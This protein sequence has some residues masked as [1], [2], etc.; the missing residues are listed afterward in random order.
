MKLTLTKMNIANI[1]LNKL[2]LNPLALDFANGILIIAIAYLINKILQFIIRKLC[3][4]NQKEENLINHSMIEATSKPIHFFIWM[5]CATSLAQLIENDIQK[6]LSDEIYFLRILLLS[7]CIIWFCFRFIN[8]YQKRF[9]ITAKMKNEK[10]D[11]LTLS[12]LEKVVKIVVFVIGSL[13]VLQHIGVNLKGILAFGGIS[14]IFLGFAS[15]DLLSN[16][17]GSLL[18]HINRPFSIGDVIYLPKERISGTV[19]SMDW[20]RTI[21]INFEKYPI[22]I[23]NSIFN[24]IIIENKSRTNNISLSEI[25]NIQYEDINKINKIIKEIENML[26]SSKDTNKKSPPS[27]YLENFNDFSLNLRIK[28]IINTGNRT[29]YNRIKHNLLLKIEEIITKNN[30]EFA[31]PLNIK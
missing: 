18:L 10:I 28:A 29:K 8:Q 16:L 31:K 5:I 7:V 12:A 23:P 14:G 15:K 24:E 13:F 3:K 17:F 2:N 25:V 1:F 22:Y 4:R 9:I 26:S 11:Y 30:A 27:V 20:R 19:K 6:D 21:I